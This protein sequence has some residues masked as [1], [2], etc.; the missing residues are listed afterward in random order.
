MTYYQNQL[1][2]AV[3]NINES[4]CDAELDV[5]TGLLDV[6]TKHIVI[7]ENCTDSDS[8]E[9]ITESSFL[10]KGDL[11]KLAK[12]VIG[13][14][15]TN[16]ESRK[17]EP[18]L[19]RILLFIPRLLKAILILIFKFINSIHHRRMYNRL[20]KFASMSDADLEDLKAW[21]IKN[22]KNPAVQ[23][24][25]DEVTQ[26]GAIYR[27]GRESYYKGFADNNYDD[28]SAD[29]N[30]DDEDI[31]EAF[32]NTSNVVVE[33]KVPDYT[34]RV[35]NLAQ[36]EK[37]DPSRMN[38]TKK[39]IQKVHDMKKSSPVENS[40]DSLIMH[41]EISTRYNF[42]KF[43]NF[44]K[45]YF[46]NF[47]EIEKELNRCI[48]S[49]KEMKP[50]PK[51]DSVSGK[52]SMIDKDSLTAPI[53]RESIRHLEALKQSFERTK[54]EYKV[55]VGQELPDT[56][57]GGWRRQSIDGY[58]KDIDEITSVLNPKTKAIESIISMVQNTPEIKALGS[59]YLTYLCQAIQ[60]EV[61][62]I[63]T[64][65]GH[66]QNECNRIKILADAA[67]DLYTAYK[68]NKGFYGLHD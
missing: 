47:D 53:A 20:R 68:K 32:Q 5:L 64:I 27:Y 55:V 50:T 6:Y 39:T 60:A 61:D 9:I 35:G 49:I 41:K 45:S 34:A 67:Y 22:D 26:Q 66:F 43:R 10:E 18:I 16:T 4:V 40:F 46:N 37:F 31:T 58:L 52:V 65:F 8:I 62:T 3:Q 14:E 54:N 28:E 44:C 25:F 17:S 33:A 38:P 7:L 57:V 29:Y 19:K 21:A 48:K 24:Y 11:K 63:K 23:A 13:S 56:F 42:E 1:L 12:H 15:E 51:V 59:D 36:K 30:Y 2:E